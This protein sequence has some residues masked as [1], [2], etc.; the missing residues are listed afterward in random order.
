MGYKTPDSIPSSVYCGRVSVP[1]D[2]YI[3]AAVKGAI[4]ELTMPENWTQLGSIT[5]EQMAD[6]M[7]TMYDEIFDGSICMIG[8]LIHYITSNP[9]SGVLP[10]DGGLY[11]RTTYPKLYDVLP[12]NLIV[13]ANSF[14]TPTIENVFML[15]AGSSYLPETVGGAETHSLSTD[16]MPIHQH[17]YSSPTINV[18]VFTAGVPDP[19]GVGLPMLPATTDFAG[20]GQ[21]HNNM[22]PFI[23]YKV[24]IVAR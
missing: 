12:A 22:P 21:A 16:E 24:G 15:A 9:P 18:D 17:G 23:A 10:C 1:D 19:T 3:L 4:L 14:N 13:D 20:G 2:I 8:A 11:A 7:Q 6:A 5:P